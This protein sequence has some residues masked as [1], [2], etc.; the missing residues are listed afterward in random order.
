M[1]GEQ[2]SSASLSGVKIDLQELAD[3]PARGRDRRRLAAVLVLSL[4]LHGAVLSV[5][6]ARF[7]ESEVAA[8]EEAIPV[9]IVT[10]PPQEPPAEEKPPEPAEETP[11]PTPPQA[12][13]EEPV[14]DYARSSDRDDVDGKDSEPPPDQKP[15]EQPEQ[16]PQDTP[17]EKPEDRPAET[18]PETPPPDAAQEQPPAPETPPTPEGLEPPAPPPQPQPQLQAAPAAPPRPQFDARALLK[19]LP[20]YDFQAPAKRQDGP[21]GNAQPGYLSTLYARIMK[22]MRH[23]IIPSTRRVHGRVVFAIL[24]NGRMGEAQ[25]AIPSGDIALDAAALAAV[26]K[27]APFPAPPNG[28]MVY[29]RFDYG[30]K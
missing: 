19:P 15:E 14:D 18:P 25:V 17:R 6:D 21:R 27:A 26:R 24:A 9:E 29:I 10:E 28:A 13:E 11:A 30:A 23:P 5:I 22:E 4:L 16:K 8:V 20:S 7:G 12:I 1:T 2:A 3:A